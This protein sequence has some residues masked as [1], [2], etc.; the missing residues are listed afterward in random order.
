MEK[1]S[2]KPKAPNTKHFFGMKETSGRRP[3]EAQTRT[4]HARGLRNGGRAGPSRKPQG[5]AKGLWQSPPLLQNLLEPTGGTP[6]LIFL[7]AVAHRP[8]RVPGYGSDG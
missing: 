2:E 1:N 6:N 8:K 5:R 7:P 3:Y 4:R